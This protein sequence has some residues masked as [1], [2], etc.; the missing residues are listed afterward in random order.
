MNECFV[1]LAAIPKTEA[2]GKGF[3][4][5]FIPG[6]REQLQHYF[7]QILDS[8]EY[9]QHFVTPLKTAIGKTYKINWQVSKLVKNDHTYIIAVGSD[10]SRFIEENSRLK[11]EMK[12]IAVGF[13]YFPLA[14]AYMNAEGEFI[15]MN[16]RFTRLFGISGGSRH[17]H[18]DSIALLAQKIGFEKMHE[19]IALIK[20][21]HYTFDHTS[22]GKPVRLRVDIRML[23]G[24]KEFAKFYIVVVQH[25]N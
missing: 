6:D 1:N 10:I 24:T 18:F 23:Q 20:E 9:H 12:S 14:V 22:R 16:A 8:D 25:S 4:E 3:F 17:I 11:Q 21:M 7:K 13:D 5:T 15:K 2:L 19:N